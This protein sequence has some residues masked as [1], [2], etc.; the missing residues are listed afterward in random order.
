MTRRA[1]LPA[2]QVMPPSSAQFP[3]RGSLIFIADLHLDPTSPA[4]LAAF[5]DFL[6][7]LLQPPRPA[8]LY[9]LGDLFDVWLGRG[10]LSDPRS[11]QI[12]SS[13]KSLSEA[14]VTV[15]VVKGN[16]DHL[17]EGRFSNLSGAI[18]VEEALSI[19]L[20]SRRAFLCHGDHLIREDRPHQRLRTILR[21]VV[22]QML[23]AEL[24]IRWVNAV[25][26]WIRKKS[27][28]QDTQRRSEI[29]GIPPHAAARIFRGGHDILITGHVHEER[30]RTLAVDGRTCE[31]Y[32]LGAWEGQG[33]V[34]EFNGSEL[35]FQRIP[36]SVPAENSLCAGDCS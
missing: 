20:G 25:A 9:I 10:S 8:A 3:P 15:T 32:S 5:E 26:R 35:S 24:P 36:L 14:G 31:L 27:H 29:A 11:L 19:S 28:S 13:L 7:K 33:S 22:V 12:L 2:G 21:G 16:R 30:R 17:L 34:L 1:G 4:R 18:L 23:A 6:S